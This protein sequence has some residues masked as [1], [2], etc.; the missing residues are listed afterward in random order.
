MCLKI[1]M[2]GMRKKIALFTEYSKKT[3][4]GHYF[5]SLQIKNELIK[6]YYCELRSN[7]NL[8][9]INSLI[10]KNKYDLVIYD[11]KKYSKTLF[12]NDTNYI[13]FDNKQKFHKNLININPLIFSNKVFH[14]PKW[15]PFPNDFFKTKINKPKKNFYSLL[16]VQGATDAYN[17]INK[18]LKCLKYL[19]QTK[20][21]LCLIKIP[22]KNK[23]Y[24]L[25]K[26]KIKI[27]NVS[28]I[29]KISSLLKKIDLAITACGNFSLEISFFGIP[30]VT[31]TLK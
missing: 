14:G 7:T 6:K 9:K 29:K 31:A 16:I 27:K 10:K 8:I 15:Y 19:N 30:S 28:Q 25:E 12:R 21:K 24:F 1:V 2:L 11:F 17:N 3:G 4:K 18:I 13:A 23:V 26:N 20:I 5:R 22:Q